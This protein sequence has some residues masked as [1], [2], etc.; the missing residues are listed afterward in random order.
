MTK[1][2]TVYKLNS[3]FIFNKKNHMII[4]EDYYIVYLYLENSVSSLRVVHSIDSAE[5]I[6]YSN[7]TVTERDD[8]TSHGTRWQCTAKKFYY[9][10]FDA[11]R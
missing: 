3:K 1:H 5:I 4:Y 8:Y 9:G 2:L 6:Q 10:V 11:Y 7:L